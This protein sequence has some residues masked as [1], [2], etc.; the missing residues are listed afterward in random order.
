MLLLRAVGLVFALIEAALALRLMLPFVRVPKNLEHFVPIIV[1]ASD[2]LMAPFKL[3]M[4]PY[5]LG[6]L[7]RLP[8][9]VDLGFSNYVDKI[10]PAVLVAMVGWGIVGGIA[11]F[12]LRNVIKVGA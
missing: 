2:W 7:T 10:D 6:K 11:V 5:E 8:G 12:V 3:V 9:E 4:Q 1:S